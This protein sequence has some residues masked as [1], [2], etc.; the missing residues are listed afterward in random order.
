MLRDLP[1]KILQY[2]IMKYDESSK[3]TEAI[4]EAEVE[5]ASAEVSQWPHADMPGL[6]A[7]SRYNRLELINP[8]ADCVVVGDANL[9]FSHCLAKHRTELCHVGRVIATTFEDLA[10]LK[11]RYTEIEQTIQELSDM[12]SEVYHNVDCTRLAVDMRF[13]GLQ[14]QLGAVYYNFPHAGAVT[15]YYDGHPF[16][17]WRH[18]NLMHLF[19]RALRSFVQPS[20]SVK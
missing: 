15:G 7:L 8:A 18:E 19:F 20:G 3:I 17:R 4:D 13:L 14:G 10:T 11:E 9:T 16:V 2:V 12:H 5:V 6:F 1:Y